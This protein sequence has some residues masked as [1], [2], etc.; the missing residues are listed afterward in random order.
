VTWGSASADRSFTK[1][2]H[3]LFVFIAPLR[4]PVDAIL[5][6]GRRRRSGPL[7]ARPTAA[8]SSQ[9][10][11]VRG[12]LRRRCEP[13]AHGASRARQKAS[14]T[15]SAGEGVRTIQGFGHGRR[16]APSTASAPDGA[17]APSTASA[18]GGARTPKAS[19]NGGAA[20]STVS[21][22]GGARSGNGFGPRRCTAL[23]Q[24]LRLTA[25]EPP[26]DP[27]SRAGPGKEN[28]QKRQEGNGRSDAVR[29]PAR[30]ILRGV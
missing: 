13:A 24:M 15:A 4:W 7:G 14:T 30:G 18:A 27:K 21:A 25:H 16:A 19:A 9:S 20:S 17:P 1:A 28:V 12:P 29:L 6:F 23:N 2:E 11:P 5:D 22:A 26:L 3:R 10:G 8:R